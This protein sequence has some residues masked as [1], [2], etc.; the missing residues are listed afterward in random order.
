LIIGYLII[1][2]P[3]EIHY[4][5]RPGRPIPGST[6]SQWTGGLRRMPAWRVAQAYVLLEL[7]GLE[8]EQAALA[9]ALPKAHPVWRCLR[10]AAQHVDVLAKDA[11]VGPWL[12]PFRAAMVEWLRSAQHLSQTR[13]ETAAGYEQFYQHITRP[14]T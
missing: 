6:F 2:P 14:T 8:L 12:M 4:D 3:G 7:K 1:H 10:L 9:M 5:L 11:E 13:A